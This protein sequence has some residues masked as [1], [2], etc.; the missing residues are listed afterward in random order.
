MQPRETIAQVIEDNFA[1]TPWGMCTTVSDYIIQ[2]LGEAGY[3]IVQRGWK[4]KESVVMFYE[5]REYIVAP[6]L[7]GDMPRMMVMA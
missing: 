1:E 3:E 7:T 6:P 4:A 5:P 2:Q